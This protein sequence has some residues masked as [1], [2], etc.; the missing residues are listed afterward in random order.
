MWPDFPAYE[1]VGRWEAEAYDPGAWRNDYPN[2]AFVRMTE[3]DAFWAAKII[4]AFTSEELGAIVKTAQFSDPEHERYFH[5]VLVQRQLKTG[6]FGLHLL[7][8]LDEFQVSGGDLTFANLSERHGFVARDSTSYEVSWSLYDNTASRISRVLGTPS[9]ERA[10]ELPL[11]DVEPSAFTG[12]TL[13]RVD[14]SS[15]QPDHPRWAQSVRVY[16]R[17]NGPSYDV[18][19]IERESGRGFVDML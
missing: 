16:L 6:A 4:M 12:N 8:P 13:L 15:R 3:R 17:S 1:A 10:T 7:N 19:A 5:E 18:V 14:I 9:T 11:P 2:P